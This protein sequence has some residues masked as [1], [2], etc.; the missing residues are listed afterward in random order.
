MPLST[1]GAPVSQPLADALSVPLHPDSLGAPGA[2]RH[3]WVPVPGGRLRVL[4]RAGPSPG[5][6]VLILP[7]F[8]AP[9]LPW[10]DCYRRV[11]D[12]ADLYV[13]E[14]MEK[15]SA[16]LDRPA[17]ADLSIAGLARQVAAAIA[18]LELGDC[19]IVGSCH[20]AAVLLEG[21]RLG[22]LKPRIALAFDPM[23]H[24]FPP[25]WL[26]ETVGPRLPVKL[27][28][29]LRG[30][31]GAFVLRSMRE[32]H[33]RARV[34]AFIDAAEPERWIRSAEQSARFALRGT[35]HSIDRDVVVVAGSTDDMHRPETSMAVARELPRGRFFHVPV[36]E[37]Q[38]EALVAVLA[39]AVAADRLDVLAPYAVDVHA[40]GGSQA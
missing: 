8:G 38:R 12:H 26:T 18:H 28:S 34:Q 3:H 24:L 1:S 39:R 17:E 2:A 29:R 20:G 11:M 23:D 14:T 7:G 5:Q 31:I 32:P 25:R 40:E 37:T 4:E 35:L 9:I 21:L 16:E 36:D 19:P 10:D 22:V 30:P 6:R 27:L 15:S 33:Q 13:V